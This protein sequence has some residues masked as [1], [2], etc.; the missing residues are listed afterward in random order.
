MM[1]VF[2][3]LGYSEAGAEQSARCFQVRA[4]SV[5]EAVPLVRESGLADGL[6]ELIPYPSS[7][8]GAADGPPGI[9]WYGP[10]PKGFA[11]PK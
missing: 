10:A 7:I 11:R 6:A 1:R 5:G 9:V 2:A 4:E 3:V 8:L